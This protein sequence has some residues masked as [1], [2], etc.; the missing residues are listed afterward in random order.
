MPPVRKFAY[1]VMV[2]LPRM[3]APALRSFLVMKASSAGMDPASATDPA[4]VGMSLVLML[5]LSKTGMP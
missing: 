2:A 5:S 3:M 4:V 1:S